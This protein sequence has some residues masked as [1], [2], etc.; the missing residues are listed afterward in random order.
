MLIELKN[1]N[2]NKTHPCKDFNLRQHTSIRIN[3][4]DQKNKKKKKKKVYLAC[5]CMLQCV[6]G[7]VDK[8][9][10]LGR[11]CSTLGAFLPAQRIPPIEED[12]DGMA[13]AQQAT[14]QKF[15]LVSRS[16]KKLDADSTYN[17]LCKGYLQSMQ[18]IQMYTRVRL[19]FNRSFL[20]ITIIIHGS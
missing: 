19:S 13:A 5:P 18:N 12:D 15:S 9:A 6:W 7:L 2:F 16:N 20:L 11:A 14:K 8:E 1:P 3:A 10:C 17:S 4:A